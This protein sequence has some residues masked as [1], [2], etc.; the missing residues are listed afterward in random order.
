[1]GRKNNLFVRKVTL[2]SR[3]GN[4]T[5]VEITGIVTGKITC[6]VVN[7]CSLTLKKTVHV[8]I[9]FH[10]YGIA[11]NF[12]DTGSIPVS[13]AQILNPV[14]V[15]VPHDITK[16]IVRVCIHGVNQL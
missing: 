10:I 13:A 7:I 8:N 11:E 1:M 5:L 3:N 12:A 2:L 16:R 14:L 9:R 6:R 4:S 15:Q